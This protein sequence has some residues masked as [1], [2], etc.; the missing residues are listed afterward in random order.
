MKARI[1][2]FPRTPWV[3]RLFDRVPWPAGAV[4]LAIA[5][6]TFAVFL[7]YTAAFSAAP[8]RL[9]GVA[10]GSGWM[11]EAIQDVFLGL[12]LAVAAASVRGAAG[13]FEALRPQLAG[14]PQQVEALRVQVLSCRL[15][16]LLGL[17]IALG[18]FGGI[19][20]VLDPT[21]W[22]GGFPGWSDPSLLWLGG[23]NFLN[24]CAVGFAM[25]LEL[26]LGRRFSRLGEHLRE[27]DLLDPGPLAPFSRR[28]L[29][30]V[31]WWML[32]A[33]FLSLTYAG[34][35]WA[36]ELL[37]LALVSLAAFGLTAFALPLLG[38]HRRL[39]VEKEAELLRV[40]S[41][42]REARERMLGAAP[43]AGGERLSD[44]LAWE[45]RVA[46]AHEW[47]LDASTLVRLGLFLALGL[48]SWIGGAL[49]ERL[50]SQ[51]LG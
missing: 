39:R 14:T 9:Q 45:T 22:V 30:N 36:G 16:P 34:A 12:T 15:L 48:G 40:R 2:L 11:A 25:G 20:T 27:V 19:S 21:A 28:A 7:A 31:S 38:V 42:L 10:G 5:L 50:L 18:L 47:P 23:R 6:A 17:A 37:P 26:S 49:V 44:L 3:L 51:A 43:S 1:E 24:W 35:G 8:G 13:D 29:R 32:L 33:A 41:A 46:S 4:G